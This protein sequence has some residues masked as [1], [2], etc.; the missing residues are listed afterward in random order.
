MPC[1]VRVDDSLQPA[2]LWCKHLR[3]R[4][5]HKHLLTSASNWS[6]AE[7][8]I[9]SQVRSARISIKSTRWLRTAFYTTTKWMAHHMVILQD[10]SS[11]LR[12]SPKILAYRLHLT[13]LAV[14]NSSSNLSS[15]SVAQSCVSTKTRSLVGNIRLNIRGKIA[16]I[17][18]SRSKERVPLTYQWVDKIQ[19]WQTNLTKMLSLTVVASTYRT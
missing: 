18:Y 1:L 15:S 7:C 12:Y 3:C 2:K 17:H 9:M 14:T 4:L 8:L 5:R 16:I 13:A 11:C 6:K 10:I 19:F